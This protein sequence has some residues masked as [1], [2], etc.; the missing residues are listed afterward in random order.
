MLEDMLL[1]R[2]LKHGS[3]S[4]LGIIYDK[5]KN[6]MLALAVSLSKDKGNAEDAVHDVFVSFA[7][8]AKK[9]KLRG[10]LRSY[11]LTSVA[12]RVRNI[13]KG[14]QYQTIPLDDLDDPAAIRS[15]MYWPD[16]LAIS[17]EESQRISNALDQLPYEQRE[18]VILHLQ[19]DM[20]FK[21]IANSL[22]AS[23]N[24]IK[25]RYRYGLDKLMPILDGSKKNESYRSFREV[26]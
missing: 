22:G 24:T 4:A 7:Q 19:S 15:D 11:L 3:K 23:V 18:V 16:Q 25:S 13:N 26:N 6:D 10:S 5:Y 17:V 9:L 1:V 12:N 20:T 14:K 8:F 21:A 2:K